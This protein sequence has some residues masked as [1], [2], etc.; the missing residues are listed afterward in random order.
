MNSDDFVDKLIEESEDEFNI[1]LDTLKY[2]FEHQE[3]KG[4]KQ[5]D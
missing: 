1:F 4:N 3:K 5:H 2:I